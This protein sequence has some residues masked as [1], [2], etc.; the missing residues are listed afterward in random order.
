MKRIWILLLTVLLFAGSYAQEKIVVFQGNARILTANV[1]DMNQITFAGHNSIFD[2]ANGSTE[3]LLT[4]SIDSVIF[5]NEPIG[6]KIRIIWNNNQVTIENPYQNQG[7]TITSSGANVTVNAAS[8]LPNLEYELSGNSSNGS[9]TI[10]GDKDLIL[11]LNNLNLTSSSKSAIEISTAVTSQIILEGNSMLSDAAA[12]SKNATLI[13][14][15]AFVFGG[16][17][18]LQITGVAK[19]AI[20]SSKMITVATGN[21]NIVSAASDG[22]H[23]EGF[24]MNNGSLQI[25]STLGDGIDAGENPV[26]ITGG[27]IQIASSASDMKGIKSD[28]ALTFTGGTFVINESGAQSKAI[29]SKSN[30]VISGGDFQITTSGDIVLTASGSGYDPSYSTAIK[31]NG[32]TTINGGNITITSTS[33]S[34]GGKGISAD[35]DI[36]INSGTIHI[37]TAGNGAVYTNTSGVTDAYTACCIKSNA[38]IRL[39]GGNLT[40]SSSGTGGK[41][42][43]ADQTVVIGKLG[44]DDNLLTINASTSGARFYVTGNT[45]GGGWGGGDN[46]DYA[47]PKAIKSTGDLTVN[48]GII[49]IRCTQT[50]DGGEGLESKNILTINGGIIDIQTYDDCI[51]ATKQIVITGGSVATKSTAN[52]GVD[53]NGTLTVTGGFIISNA[54]GGAEDGFDCD[55]N[56]FKITGGTMIGTGGNSSTP[57]SSVCTQHS[58]LFKATANTAVCLAKSTGE[59]LL[60]YQVPAAGSSSGGGGGPGGGGQSGSM[61][62]LYSSPQLIT[63]SYT[64][65]TG[66]TI[67]GGT[68]VNGYNTGGTYSGG[69][70]KSITVSSMVTSVQ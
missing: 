22:F 52:D 31:S 15:G 29:S 35:G 39:N 14:A 56:T 66:G 21:F 55:N 28:A 30:I 13:G 60:L 50:A 61:K 6:E 65:K 2:F 18:Y 33:S 23:S 54:A 45:G 69:T 24:T 12:N 27:T 16:N 47:N 36:V 49:T 7:I 53:S 43:N 32:S 11:Y 20:S 62:I 57:T 58:L 8:G 44:I 37:T 19:H 41:C 10:A 5:V 3:N 46:A 4:A 42:V 38:N 34:K 1:A 26:V 25:S 64:L 59:I 70:S 67:S 40:L 51:N 63:G 9:V 17:G 48:S 68:T